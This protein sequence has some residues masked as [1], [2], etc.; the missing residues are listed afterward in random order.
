MA[1]PLT[2]QQS[3]EW[4]KRNSEWAKLNSYSS[5]KLPLFAIKNLAGQQLASYR[6]KT[7]AQAITRFLDDQNALWVGFRRSA[8]KPIRREELVAVVKEA[9]Q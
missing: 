6:A 7:P 5:G 8:P 4:A 2:T 1:R 9:A 3:A